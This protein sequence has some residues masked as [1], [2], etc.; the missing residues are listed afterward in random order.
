MASLA[1]LT[2]LILFAAPPQSQVAFGPAA[3]SGSAAPAGNPVSNETSDDRAEARQAFDRGLEAVSRGEFEAAVA[4]FEQAYRIRPHPV[5]LFNLAL[6]LEKANR[7]P[8]AYELFDAVLDVIDSD[9]ERREVRRRMR[10]IA[11]EIAILEIDARPRRRLCLDGVA[12]PAGKTS[13]YRLATEPGRH[14]L[15]LDDHEFDVELLAGD[16]R[17]LLLDEADALVDDRRRGPLM[18][19]MIGLTIGGGALAVGLG[20]GAAVATGEQTRIGLAAGAAGSAGLAVAAGIVALLIETRT[21]TDPSGEPPVHG[22]S[23]P[24][25]PQLEDRLDFQLES[26]I[27]RPAEFVEFDPL[28]LPIPPIPQPALTQELPHPRSIVPPRAGA[29]A[30]KRPTITTPM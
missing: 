20:A 16:R 21:I 6:A 18:P 22:R 2:G 26:L 29:S 19:A 11:N 5:T 27:D 13:N 17:V 4:A 7:L 14:R 9:A 8:E 12:I 3:P 15:L 25:S 10:M 23:C 30:Q 28:R 1:A 24:G